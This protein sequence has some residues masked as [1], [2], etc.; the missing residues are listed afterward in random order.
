MA[1]IRRAHVPI[2]T[3]G[4]GRER[5]SRDIEISDVS[6]PAQAMADSRLSAEVTLRQFGYIREKA[7][8]VA[9]E[10]DR[11]LASREIALKGEGTPQTESLVFNAGLAGPR[12]FQFAIEPLPGEENLKNNQI[13]RLVNIS[14]SAGRILYFEGEPRWEYK[15]IHRGVEDDRSLQISS[16]V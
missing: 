11:L 10:G 5:L 13:T 4:F 6:L 12:T 14:S 16:M 2:H 9:R 8:L 7:R 3:I 15:F 1:Q